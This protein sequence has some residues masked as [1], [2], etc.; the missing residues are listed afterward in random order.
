M[1]RFN[2]DYLIE[3]RSRAGLTQHELAEKCDL[4]LNIIS[5]YERGVTIPRAR[6]TFKI[7]SA[8]GIERLDMYTESKQ[9]AA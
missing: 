3:E 9:E 2:P 7:A 1:L 6:S 4:S 8:L 5:R